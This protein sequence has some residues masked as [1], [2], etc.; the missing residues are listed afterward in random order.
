MNTNRIVRG[1]KNLQSLEIT[2]KMQ[3]FNRIYYSN[4]YRRLKMFPAAYRSSSGAL[5]CI[6]SFG[7]N[8]LEVLMMSD[9]PLE[10]F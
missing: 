6:C 9:M 3:P 7:K 1:M 2:N 8:C 4:V 10:A 5:N